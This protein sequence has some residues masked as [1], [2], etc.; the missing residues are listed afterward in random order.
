MDNSFVD[1]TGTTNAIAGIFQMFNFSPTVD[2][3]SQVGN[4]SVI[5]IGTGSGATSTAVGQILRITD[6]SGRSNL[7]RGLEI[8][9]S[10]GNNTFGVNTG[11]RTTGHT[12]GLQGITTGLAGGTSTPAAIYGENIGTTQGDILRLYTSTMTSA[13]AIA[14]L[15]QESSA[16]TGAGLQMNFG[17]GGGSFTGNFLD[18]QKNGNTQFKVTHSGTTTI[19][20]IGQISAAAG[21]LVPYGSICV[22]D[23]GTCSGTTVGLISAVNYNTGHTADLAENFYSRDSLENGDIVSAKGH[24]EVGKSST[25]SEPIIGVVS[26]KPGFV[27]A[28]DNVGSPN[29]N[30]K[31]Y[32][33]GLAGRLPV[34]VSDENGRIEIGDKIMLSNADGIGMKYD[35]S[36]ATIIGIALENF[37]GNNYLS[38]GTVETE[39]KKVPGPRV[40]TTRE[41]ERDT[42]NEGGPGDAEGGGGNSK[43]PKK[44]TE[45]ICTTQEVTVV[46]GNSPARDHETKKGKK[47]KVGKVM[48]FVNLDISGVLTA[49]G[50]TADDISNLVHYDSAYNG[51]RLTNV[52]SLGSATGNWSIDQEGNLAAKSIKTEEIEIGSPEKPTG[53]TLYDTKT[54]EPYCLQMSGGEMSTTPG[55]CGEGEK[56]EPGTIPPPASPPS[57]PTIE[58]PTEPLPDSL[59]PPEGGEVEI[60][61]PSVEEPPIVEEPIEE[62]APPPTEEV[63]EPIEVEPEPASPAPESPPALSSGDTNGDINTPE[64]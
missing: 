62:P 22:D 46:P 8:V 29:P 14:R 21:L 54:S 36:G 58:L 15:Y 30:A 11:I 63:S 16:F 2:N 53:I 51:F 31:P 57:E 6:S 4:R 23:D 61:P 25:S 40:C 33:I 32:P 42:R 64:S 50:S 60:D 10:V 44:V 52:L 3:K 9:T 7:V 24:N 17:A 55:K 19:G 59:T 47:V 41:V 49:T 20:Q 38:D 56:D 13:T 37:Q 28:A 18:L 39:T 43:P 26:T 35:G 12:F 5:N 45:E 27:L 34:K 1:Q 48:M